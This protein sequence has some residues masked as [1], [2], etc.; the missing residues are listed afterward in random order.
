[1]VTPKI[2]LGPLLA[3]IRVLDPIR[4]E[5][6]TIYPLAG[7]LGSGPSYL[8]LDE[9]L[10]TGSLRIGEVDQGG[11]VPELFMENQGN[12]PVFILD[13]EVLEGGKQTRVL[14]SALLVGAGTKTVVPVSCVER[15]RWSFRHQGFS[16]PSYS[17]S[18]LRSMKARMTTDS[19]NM[20]TGHRTD[21]GKI[22]R[23]VDMLLGASGAHS[24]TFE[25]L[26]G[27]SAA[28][29]EREKFLNDV[30]LPEEASGVAVAHR[31][32]LLS[33]DLFDRPETLK[34]LWKK[35]TSG[36]VLDLLREKEERSKEGPPDPEPLLRRAAGSDWKD[37]PAVAIGEEMRLREKDLVGTALSLDGHV[38][39]LSLFP[40]EEESFE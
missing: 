20:G 34:K 28:R 37:E 27:V 7:Q 22:W 16:S 21:Q 38:L 36:L 3:S 40:L 2:P 30:R 8:T 18:K 17:H 6:L 31:S 39:H 19:Q 35:L 25:Y 9:A 13:G 14:N 29:G 23:E 4:F 33:V 5:E 10:Q 15:G 26:A 24:P 12:D 32:R 11:R 1:M